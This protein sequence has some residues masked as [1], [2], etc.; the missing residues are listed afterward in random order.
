MFRLA[1]AWPWPKLEPR[2]LGGTLSPGC[3][4]RPGHTS[5]MFVFKSASAHTLSC[6]CALAVYYAHMYHGQCP[7]CLCSYIRTATGRSVSGKGQGVYMRSKG[8]D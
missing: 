7:S 4:L 3:A 8:K 5:D 1:C 6:M 2:P